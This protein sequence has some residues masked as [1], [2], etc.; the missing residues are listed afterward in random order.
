MILETPVGLVT[1]PG[2][3]Y[4]RSDCA[5]LLVFSRTVNPLTY[6]YESPAVR[7][8]ERKAGNVPSGTCPARGFRPIEGYDHNP[9]CNHHDE[10]HPAREAPSVLGGER[11]APDKR[12]DGYRGTGMV[13]VSP[14]RGG[15]RKAECA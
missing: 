13:L 10:P 5:N 11:L 7:R 15:E 14:G 12:H 1:V 6:L 9:Q 4:V 8:S 2:F 3:L